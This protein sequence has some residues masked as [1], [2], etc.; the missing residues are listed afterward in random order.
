M[1]TPRAFIVTFVFGL[2]CACRASASEDDD[3][4]SAQFMLRDLKKY[5]LAEEHLEGSIRRVTLS[6]DGSF[7]ALELMEKNNERLC[8]FN[9]VTKEK[10]FL[11][12]RTELEG[13]SDWLKSPLAQ[14]YHRLD[15]DAQWNPQNIHGAQWLSFVSNGIDN[16]FDIFL[17][18]Q[19]TKRYIRV[20]S[21]FDRDYAPRWSFDGSSLCYLTSRDSTQ[22]IHFIDDFGSLVRQIE[23]FSFTY[24]HIPILS[25]LYVID[26][27]PSR[28]KTPSLTFKKIF[29]APAWLTD[30]EL[31]VI[32]HDARSSFARLTILNIMDDIP[33]RMSIAL[34][35]INH[36]LSLPEDKTVIL[37]ATAPQ[38]SQLTELH[39][40]TTMESQEGFTLTEKGKNDVHLKR[41]FRPMTGD[42]RTFLTCVNAEGEE[43]LVMNSID[44]NE[45]T[46]DQITFP[47]SMRLEDREITSCDVRTLSS[48]G[49]VQSILFSYIENGKNYFSTARLILPTDV[50]RNGLRSKTIFFVGGAGAFVRYTGDG[51]TGDFRPTGELWMGVEPFR[52]QYPHL[53]VGLSSGY[54]PLTGTS[55][56]LD[57]FSKYLWYGEAFAKAG[58]QL[59]SEYEP[60]I[61]V[62]VGKGILNEKLSTGALRKPILLTIGAGVDFYLNPSLTLNVEL[63]HRKLNVDIDKLRPSQP[64]NDSFVTIGFGMSYR[65]G[66]QL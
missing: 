21:S 54:V 64:K 63:Q 52:F 36:V 60:W 28:L 9:L 35:S 3:R 25:D 31:L 65:F 8:I 61:Y 37:L 5:S 10:F 33:R 16:H 51:A 41:G 55:S 44:R 46:S 30:V 59:S 2:S 43:F 57:S 56:S 53:S 13:Y 11:D 40:Y 17:F 62:G 66:I 19:N 47:E 22:Q 15:F 12:P 14:L 48:D 29:D 23:Q 24:S 58:Y 18:N 50:E 4:V 45:P 27:F 39:W 7:A 20:T 1:N 34:D 6:P 49:T 32:D 38:D 26:I 42:G